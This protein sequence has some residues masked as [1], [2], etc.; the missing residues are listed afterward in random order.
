[1]RPNFKRNAIA[2]LVAPALGAGAAYAQDSEKQTQQQLQ[3]QKQAQGQEKK[4]D[5]ST[6]DISKLYRNTWSAD[7]MIDTD[8]RGANGEEIGEVKDIIVDRK[9]NIQR[10]VVEVGGFLEMG[11]QH[12]G[13]PWKDVQIGPNMEYVEVPLR[14]IEGGTY[15]LYGVA[16]QGEDVYVGR[17]AWRV[18]ELIGDYASLMDVPRYGMVTDALFDRKGKLQGL[19]VSRTAGAWGAAGWYGY[20]YYGYY[21]GYAYAFPYRST[22]VADRG[23]FDYGELAQESEFAGEESEERQQQAQSRQGAAARGGSAEQQQRQKK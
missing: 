15:S 6:W 13:V 7:E 5:L 14:E 18:N 10:V 4:Q 21:P 20:P 12:M 19:V 9:G 23:R 22:E 3:K 16:P 2:M 11:D 1:M 8:V 17:N